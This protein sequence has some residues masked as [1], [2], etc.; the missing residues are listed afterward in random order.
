RV[1]EVVV[2]QRLIFQKRLACGDRIT[3]VSDL[4]AALIPC[5]LE[6]RE[7]RYPIKPAG[8]AALQPG[9]MRSGHAERYMKF[10]SLVVA[11]VA[12][13]LLAVVVHAQS[14]R[15]EPAR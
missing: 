11:C 9:L 7:F 6:A 2:Q 1:T 8:F 12:T 5:L 14:P 3:G 15:P 13:L 10:R 4:F